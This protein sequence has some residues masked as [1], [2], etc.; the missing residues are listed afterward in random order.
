MNRWQDG[1]LITAGIVGVVLVI[2]MLSVYAKSPGTP[3]DS[4]AFGRLTATTWCRTNAGFAGPIYT[5]YEFNADGTFEYIY[6][7]PEYQKREAGTWSL[8][9]ASAIQGLVF[10]STGATR[11]FSLEE[12]SISFGSETLRACKKLS[13]RPDASA[14]NLPPVITSDTFNILTS[15]PWERTHRLNAATAATAYVFRPD[16]HYMATFRDGEC[17]YE[18]T[19]DLNGDWVGLSIPEEDCDFRFIGPRYDAFLFRQDGAFAIIA[20]TYYTRVPWDS[21]ESVLP[22]M[23][24]SDAGRIYMLLH[25]PL[26]SNVPALVR[27]VFENATPHEVTIKKFHLYQAPVTRGQTVYN[28]AGSPRTSLWA[29]TNLPQSVAAGASLVFYSEIVLT[30]AGEIELGVEAVFSAPGVT[31]AGGPQYIVE[32]SQD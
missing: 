28:N 19:W 22:V 8:A 32:L 14:A 24:N 11:F 23:S 25:E 30:G 31:V 20:N 29:L 7:A 21:R 9:P 1:Q 12:G 5:S 26:R 17:S 3:L 6:D 13:A 16:G 18:G 10:M 27:V 4:S 2:V 15:T